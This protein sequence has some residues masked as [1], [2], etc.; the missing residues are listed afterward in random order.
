M[1]A[2]LSPLETAADE[3]EKGGQVNA[4]AADNCSQRCTF[5]RKTSLKCEDMTL[6]LTDLTEPLK[7]HNTADWFTG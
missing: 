5:R 4:S 1:L 3:T 7:Q 6:V 2:L